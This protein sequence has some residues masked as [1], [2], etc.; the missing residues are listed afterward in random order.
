MFTKGSGW[1]VTSDFSRIQRGQTKPVNFVLS[2]SSALTACPTTV[3]LCITSDDNQCVPF[4]V[5]LNCANFQSG[6]TFTFIDYDGSVQ[7]GMNEFL[8]QFN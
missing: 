1:T 4:N 3:P 5:T 8:L 6:Y 7:Y 2:S